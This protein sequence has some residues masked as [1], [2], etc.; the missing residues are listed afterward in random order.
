MDMR[1]LGRKSGEARRRPNPER[2][3]DCLRTYLKREVPPERIWQA[4]EAAMLGNNDSARVSASRV[5]MDALSEPEQDR[6]QQRQVDRALKG[7]PVTRSRLSP[8]EWTREGG[9]A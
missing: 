4:L 9:I 8:L 3:N 7:R 6:Q 2:V 5:L 1:A